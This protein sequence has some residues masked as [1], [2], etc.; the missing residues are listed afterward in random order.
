MAASMSCGGAAGPSCAP[1][2][3]DTLSVHGRLPAERS[4]P[5]W[6]P[7][8][9]LSLR[10]SG[11]WI[12]DFWFATEGEDVHVF[13]LHAPRDLGHPDLRHS[14]AQIGHAVSRDLRSWEVLPTALSPGP[15]GAF[16]DLATWTGSILEAGGRW[17]LFYSG[18]S[19]RGDGRVQR[20][21]L[22]TSE[23]LRRWERQPVLVEADPRWY[24]TRRDHSDGEETWRDPWVF[25]DPADG[26][27]HMVVC[28]RV[29]HGP[30]D[31]RGVLGHAWS[32]DLRS[33]EAGPPLSEP[34][35]F[36]QLEVPQV[37]RLGGTWRAI[38]SAGWSDH[39]AARLARSGVVAE[40]GTHYLVGGGPLGPY[41]LDRDEFLL[42]DAQVSFYAGR[43]VRHRGAWW[44]LAWRHA[45]GRGRFFGELSDPMAL[46]VDQAGSL[47]VSDSPLGARQA[48]AADRE[49]G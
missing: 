16:D 33:W 7:E 18:I 1:W 43:V 20:V 28:A 38:F 12:W 5:G 22:A 14:H 31:G 49:P 29:N 10:L 47:W 45:D 6:R 9:A 25:R 8:E 41:A 17:H 27:F 19:T 21:G 4:S 36:R 11:H 26:R 48:P 37:V 3:L 15:P 39:S 24:E 40:G 23:D 30:P 34:G 42:G 35:E 2:S 32:T 44:L 46:T 13:Y